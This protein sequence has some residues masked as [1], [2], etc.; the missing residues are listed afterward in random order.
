MDLMEGLGN[1]LNTREPIV[2]T[3]DEEEKEVTYSFIL[4]PKVQM[5][6]KSRLWTTVLLQWQLMERDPRQ[7]N[8]K[9]TQEMTFLIGRTK[10]LAL[11]LFQDLGG[12]YVHIF[13]LICKVRLQ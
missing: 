12:Q 6:Y 11:L 5:R 3:M 1:D 4:H 9:P 8:M 2:F 13:G 10:I 7:M